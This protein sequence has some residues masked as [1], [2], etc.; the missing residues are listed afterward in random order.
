MNSIY[1]IYSS[2]INPN[3]LTWI[4]SLKKSHYLSNYLTPRK[5]YSLKSQE[6][7]FEKLKHVNLLLKKQR[8]KWILFKTRPCTLQQ[9]I[10]SHTFEQ[11]FKSIMNF[12]LVFLTVSYLCSRVTPNFLFS[13]SKIFYKQNHNLVN[14]K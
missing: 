8:W 9:Q 13:H 11:T 7:I 1:S 2:S 14:L 3:T 10:N 5:A 12:S 4:C 6:L